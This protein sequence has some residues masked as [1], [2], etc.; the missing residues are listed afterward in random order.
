MTLAAIDRL[1]HD[2]TIFELNGESYRRKKAASDKHSQRDNKRR[3]QS[4]DDNHPPQ[5]D[6][7]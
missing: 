5:K 7:K 6:P 4:S 3:R 1:V 2:A